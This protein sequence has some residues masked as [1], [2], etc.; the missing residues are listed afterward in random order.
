[1]PLSG[2]I[3]FCLFCL[4]RRLCVTTSL[5]SVLLVL[6][7][8]SASSSSWSMS[9]G[10]FVGYTLPTFGD[11][12]LISAA[13]LHNLVEFQNNFLMLKKDIRSHP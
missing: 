11:L 9:L 5:V 10:S 1:M 4:G 6:S 13:T 7:V 2:S 8:K 12:L 3:T